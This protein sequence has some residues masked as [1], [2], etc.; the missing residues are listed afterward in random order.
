[1]V[2]QIPFLEKFFWTFLG[3]RELNVSVLCLIIFIKLI[4]LNF[5]S[6]CKNQMHVDFKVD[7]F[8]MKIQVIFSRGNWKSP[9]N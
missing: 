5:P 6:T 7:F 1:M 9:R 4:C 3:L 2:V 8:C